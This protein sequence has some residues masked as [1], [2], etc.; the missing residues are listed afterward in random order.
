LRG[1]IEARGGLERATEI[2]AEA[3]AAR[4]GQNAMESRIC[5]FVIAARR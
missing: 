2:A 1:E 3:L 5:A 4:F